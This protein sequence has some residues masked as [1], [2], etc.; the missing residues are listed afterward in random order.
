MIEV[1][2]LQTLL[3]HTGFVDG[4]E[5][6]ELHSIRISN[7]INML[8]ENFMFLHNSWPKNA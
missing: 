2:L 6:L 7:I 1:F 4:Q 5:P 8:L 3:L